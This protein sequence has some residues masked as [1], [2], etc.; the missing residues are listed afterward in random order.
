MLDISRMN[1]NNAAKEYAARSQS[2]NIFSGSEQPNCNSRPG[3]KMGGGQVASNIAFGDGEDYVAES[4][5]APQ[6]APFLTDDNAVNT[7]GRLGGYVNQSDS[8]VEASEEETRQVEY[9]RPEPVVMVTPEA[10]I[11]PNGNSKVAREHKAR[12]MTSHIFDSPDAVPQQ[13]QR[14]T[15]GNNGYNNAKISQIF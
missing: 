15:R 11:K 1:M 10:D 9:S 14:N 8:L 7:H 6:P 3:K 12:N 2:S 4:R 13:Q 5:R